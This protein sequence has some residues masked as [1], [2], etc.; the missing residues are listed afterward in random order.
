MLFFLFFLLLLLLLLLFVF[1][2]VLFSYL[3][4]IFFI[5]FHFF[6][7]NDILTEIIFI[8]LQG[9]STN[10]S[11]CSLTL[12]MKAWIPLLSPTSCPCSPTISRGITIV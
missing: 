3:F 1:L 8:F 10:L 2:V 11:R 9:K 7:V 6:N 4:R 12:K 5:L